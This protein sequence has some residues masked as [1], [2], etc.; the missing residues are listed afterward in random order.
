MKEI[1][2]RNIRFEDSRQLR[3]LDAI[4]QMELLERLRDEG[5]IT[6]HDYWLLIG[7]YRIIHEK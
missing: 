6:Q 1:S 4:A 7:S 5:V 3:I 2:K